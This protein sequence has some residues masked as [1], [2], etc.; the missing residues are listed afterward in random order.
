MVFV[1]NTLIRSS[2]L[3]VRRP[4]SLQQSPLLTNFHQKMTTVAAVY[5]PSFNLL[6]WPWQV[7][8][9]YL[10]SFLQEDSI[11]NMSSTLKKRRAKMNKHKLKKRR[12]KN[13]MKTKK[14]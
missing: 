11:W 4:L 6:R 5:S 10:P 12:K 1:I 8:S 2:S 3:L 14:R 7:T 13:R 9:I